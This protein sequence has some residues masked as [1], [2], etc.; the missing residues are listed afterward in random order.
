MQTK[1]QCVGVFTGLILWAATLYVIIFYQKD[2][3]AWASITPFHMLILGAIIIILSIII[4]TLIRAFR[5]DTE[6][7][8]CPY[9]FRGLSHSRRKRKQR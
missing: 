2:I 7:E 6:G 5:K 9:A 3:L 1:C 4:M 8:S